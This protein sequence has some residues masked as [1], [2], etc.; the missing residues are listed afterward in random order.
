MPHR[1]CPLCNSDN[2]Q[3]YHKDNKRDYYLCGV[4]HLVFV[5][6][7][8]LLSAQDEKAQYDFHENDPAD[9]NYR[10]FLN[11]I[12]LPM[13]NLIQSR[14]KGLDY[15]S[16]P[17]PT[18]SV[19]FEEQGYDIQI[20]DY[21]YANNPE[22]LNDTYDFITCTET[23]EHIHNPKTDLVRLWKQLNVNGYLG[24]MTKQVDTKERFSSWHYKN[25]PTHVCFYSKTTF[26]WLAKQWQASIVYENEDIVIFQKNNET[27]A[28]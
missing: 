15:G 21:F 14:A 17:G 16:G 1:H 22:V 20:Y 9:P 27:H 26:N 19:M 24:V 11:R 12:F 25:D 10:E 13:I 18:L 8:Q 6:E 5:P 2:T 7:H 4:C 28:E 23:I 3:H